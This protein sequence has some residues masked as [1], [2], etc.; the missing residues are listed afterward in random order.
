MIL[1]KDLRYI[2][3]ET[4]KLKIVYT[5]GMVVCAI[6]LILRKLRQVD[7]IKFKSSL[8]YIVSAGLARVR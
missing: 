1:I 8:G 5:A 2:I 7:C 4:E 3:R 6:I